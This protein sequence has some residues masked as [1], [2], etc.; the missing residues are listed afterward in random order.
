MVC[1]GFMP[2]GTSLEGNPQ[3]N[4]GSRIFWWTFYIWEAEKTTNGSAKIMYLSTFTIAPW[5][6]HKN[7]TIPHTNRAVSVADQLIFST[8]KEDIEGI[9][10]L[11]REHKPIEKAWKSNDV[12]LKKH[13]PCQSRLSFWWR[14]MGSISTKKELQGP[15]FPKLFPLAT[16]A[17]SSLR[18]GPLPPPPW[19]NESKFGR[20]ILFLN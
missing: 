2:F 17:P 9:R 7:T 14:K 8:L 11:V 18:G 4:C 15:P 12:F 13:H 6:K 1:P 3:K 5:K 16:L 10:G 20:K 19:R